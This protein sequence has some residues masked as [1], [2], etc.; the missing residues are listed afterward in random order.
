MT[1]P[2]SSSHGH[3]ILVVTPNDGA[4]P[5]YRAYLVAEDDPM[6]ARSVVARHLRPAKI[7]HTLAAFPDVLRQLVGLEPGSAIRHW[8]VRVSPAINHS[9]RE[10]VGPVKMAAVSNPPSW[11]KWRLEHDASYFLLSNI[12]QFTV[13]LEDG[14]L[15]E[16]QK[17]GVRVL[18]AESMR[19]LDKIGMRVAL[20]GVSPTSALM[21]T[22]LIAPA[23]IPLVG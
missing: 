23:A 14:S 10:C 8:I 9:I 5:S 1:A 16:R 13:A 2:S 15:N 19:L 17:R 21:P 18:R 22:L 3:V 4:Q 12:E 20:R 6:K 11:I 7:A